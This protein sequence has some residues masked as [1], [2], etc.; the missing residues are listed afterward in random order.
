MKK[1]LTLVVPNPS[2][3]FVPGLLVGVKDIDS[4]VDRRPK[5]LET[6]AVGRVQGYKRDG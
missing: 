5:H 4:W 6:G 2:E 3:R 1:Y